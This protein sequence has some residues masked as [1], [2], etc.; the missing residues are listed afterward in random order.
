MGIKILDCQKADNCFAN[1]SSYAYTLSSP[2]DDRLLHL[3]SGWGRMKVRR[4]FR[5]PFFMLDTDQGIQVKGILNETIIKAGFSGDDW[6]EL[7]MDFEKR[8]CGCEDSAKRCDGLGECCG[9][10]AKCC[11]RTAEC[12]NRTAECCNRTAEC[13]DNTAECCNRTADCCDNTA[14]CCNGT[15]D[16]CDNTAECRDNTAECCNG[17]AECCDNT[18]ECCDNTA[19]CCSSSN[20]FKQGI[21][22][23]TESVCPVCLKKVEARKVR[24]GNQVFLEKSCPEHGDF[25][26]LIWNGAPAYETFDRERCFVSPVAPAVKADRGCPDDCGLCPQHRQRTCCVLLEVTSRCNLVCPVCFASSQAE[27]DAQTAGSKNEP[28]LENI[29]HRFE[30]MMGMGGPFN[31]QLSGG[32]PTMRNDLADIIRMGKE[33]GFPFFQLNTN[34]I[35]IGKDF[36][37][38]KEL[39]DA[40]LDCVFLQF[41][42]LREETY[43]ALRGRELLK[44]KMDAIAAC[45]RAHVGVVLVPVIV[46]GINDGEVGD[47]LNFALEHMP[48]VRGVHFQP[49]SQFGRYDPRL[50]KKHFTLPDLLRAIETQTGGKMKAEH[51]SPGNAENPYCSFSGNFVLQKDGTLQTWGKEKT[52]G[53]GTE[54]ASRKAREFVARQWAAPPEPYRCSDSPFHSRP[55]CCDT[56]SLDDFLER[57]E[58]DTLAV[59]AMG[60]MD[61]W[62]LDLDR[63]KEC[64]IHVVTG[65][66]PV[67]LIPFCAYNLTAQDGTCKYRGH[68][69]GN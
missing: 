30:A 14:E 31:I 44:E 48:A 68:E 32:E 27:T 66:E 36:A 12:C 2:V 56:S 43:R 54:D 57:L 9:G 52:C 18:A 39:A 7:K 53:C 58:H 21:L 3:L 6:E 5:R 51:F 13:C 19:E 25:R 16:C 62:T 8:L 24:A 4:D 15:A 17:T 11:D 38:L 60:F 34:G 61:A 26:A 10:T 29:R 49:A 67:R 41:D 69:K 22:G 45:V 50:S 47:I 37:Y 63:L 23:Y 65:E 33:T 46:P 40:G 42:G 28:D 64:Y 35:R 1:A 20:A 55:A 59:S